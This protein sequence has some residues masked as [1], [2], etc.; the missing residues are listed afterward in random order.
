MAGVPT[1]EYEKYWQS[2]G[3]SL[4][5]QYK[6]LI[7]EYP[8]AESSITQVY[9]TINDITALAGCTPAYV[10]LH[11]ADAVLDVIVLA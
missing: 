4:R 9:N 1:P 7:Q 3:Q 11:I 2:E 5:D 6:N 10:I 8:D